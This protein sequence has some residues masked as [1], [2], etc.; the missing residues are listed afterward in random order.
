MV[1]AFVFVAVLL[2]ATQVLAQS[3]PEAGAWSRY[4]DSL[5]ESQREWQGHIEWSVNQ[6]FQCQRSVD[7]RSPCNYFVGRALHRI[8]RIECFKTGADSWLPANQIADHVSSN[9]AEWMKI[10]SGSNQSALAQAQ[11]DANAGAAVIAVS[12]GS[13]YGHVALIVAGKM[14]LSNRWGLY[15]PNS[16][17]MFL[18][19]P[20]K[21]YV[22]KHLAHAWSNSSDV[23]LYVHVCSATRLFAECVSGSSE[24]TLPGLPS[25]VLLP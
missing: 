2:L 8:Y 10:G 20:G 12:Q 4:V 14:S 23:E 24:G 22:G 11:A 9:P 19:R 21:S 3:N 17:S 15:A 1:R 6:L 25:P 7:D 5:T 13:N 18:D 16:A